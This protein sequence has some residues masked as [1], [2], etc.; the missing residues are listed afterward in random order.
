MIEPHV[1]VCPP[2]T[3]KNATP[4]KELGCVRLKALIDTGAEC[5]FINAKKVEKLEGYA[6]KG[7]RRPVASMCAGS[8]AAWAR[9]I[10]VQVTA[11]GCPPEK[12]CALGTNGQPVE[13][14]DFVIGFDYMKKVGMWVKVAPGRGGGT[15]GCA[16][17]AAGPAKRDTAAPKKKTAS[18][19]T[20]AKR[21][22]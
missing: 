3:P 7:C 15:F 20:A 17:G 16:K 6:K 8:D 1:W 21:R 19:R 2:G 5:S 11:P 22:R 18:K 13:G 12:V 9:G 10:D 4:S 14:I